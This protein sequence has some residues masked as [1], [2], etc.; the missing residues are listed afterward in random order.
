MNLLVT[1]ANGFIG[2]NLCETLRSR[3]DRLLPVD[4]D[5]TQAELAAMAAEADFVFH[6][7]GVNRP[8]NE[9]EFQTGNADFTETLLRLLEQG[10]KP[11]V[12]MSGSTQ[13]ALDNPY[14]RSKRNA[15]KALLAYGVRTGAKVYPYRLT[16]AF[17][18]W[19]RPNYNSAVATFCYNIARGLPITVS[20]PAHEMRLN[21]IDDIVAEFVRALE[22]CPMV[23]EDGFCHVMPEHGATLG[24][25]V[26]LIRTFHESRDTLALPDQRDAFTRK[27]FATYQSFLPPEEL[28]YRPV[29]HAD[30]RGS[31]TELLHMDGYGQISV[32][33]QKPHIVKGE[34]WHHTKHEKFIVVA[35]SGIIR[36]RS[37]Q[38]E[39]IVQYAVDGAT[40]TVVDIP[41]GYTHNIENLGD[42]DMVT[43]MWANEI[44]DPE[45]PDTYRLPV[46][47]EEE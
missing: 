16:N 39:E 7:A 40:P 6:L 27:L 35:G 36:L 45:H 26:A 2:K 37:V 15:E 25:I 21:Y 9:L 38:N 8:Q 30:M 33:V 10:E 14:G 13:A 23:G 3:G 43:L 17:G 32:N 11:P 22:G 19:S 28:A 44:F 20:D 18:K 47:P 5:T 31:F 12:L 1:G 29:T 34:H 24:E 4:V 42:T 46:Q 41:P